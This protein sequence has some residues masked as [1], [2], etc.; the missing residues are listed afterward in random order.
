MKRNGSPV[1]KG[2]EGRRSRQRATTIANYESSAGRISIRPLDDLFEP[3]V[4]R[5]QPVRQ[6][7]L[8]TSLPPDRL[9]PMLRQG[10]LSLAHR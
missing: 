2:V 1:S 9:K 10:Y 5:E 7:T 4:E 6:E 8:P 3:T